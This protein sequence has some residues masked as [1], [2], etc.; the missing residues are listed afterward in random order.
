[1]I[2]EPSEL[3]PATGPKETVPPDPASIVAFDGCA[4]TLIKTPVPTVVN[5]YDCALPVTFS[6]TVKLNVVSI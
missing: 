1:M 4:V 3:I 2:V 5:A 6:V